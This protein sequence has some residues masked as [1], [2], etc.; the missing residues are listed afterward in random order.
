[1]RVPNW[2]ARMSQ[3]QTLYEGHSFHQGLIWWFIR[4][5]IGWALR[6]RY[7][8]PKDLPPELIALVR[9]LD[10]DDCLFPSGKT[11]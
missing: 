8:V 7:Q 6:K 11:T 9:K 4:E 5:Q 1:M 3:A 2:G 10:E